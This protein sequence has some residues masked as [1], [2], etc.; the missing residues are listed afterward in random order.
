MVPGC[1]INQEDTILVVA[2]R[3]KVPLVNNYEDDPSSMENRFFV[4]ISLPE[5]VINYE[6]FRPVSV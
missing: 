1:S 2:D 5:R 4:G 3:T 6:T